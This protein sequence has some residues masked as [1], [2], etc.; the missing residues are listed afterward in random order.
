[1][2]WEKIKKAINIRAMQV[3]FQASSYVLKNK[4]YDCQRLRL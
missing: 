1:M 2:Y 3:E 4:L